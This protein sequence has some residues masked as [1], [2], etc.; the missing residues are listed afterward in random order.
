M[1]AVESVSAVTSTPA[2]TP[3][4]KVALSAADAALCARFADMLL[5]E[6]GLSANTV[7]AYGG[8]LAA[9]ARWC[10]ARGHTL[11]EATREDIVAHLAAR[12]EA[13]RSARSSARLL[14]ALR[15]FFGW[16]AREG[17]IGSDPTRL[18]VSP[19]IGRS[20]PAVPGERE[21]ERL[22]AAPDT[23]EDI[24]LRDRAMLETLYG[25]G[26]RVSELV[27]LEVD[28]INRRQGALRVSG[29]GG[30]ERLVPLG[31]PALE[32]IARYERD[33]RRELLGGRTSEALFV[34]ARGAAMTRQAFWY[35]VRQ[36]AR[37]AGIERRLSPHTLRHAFAT[38]LVNHDADLRVVQLL[39]GHR[40]LSTTQIYTHVARERLK[41]LHR[42]HHP[43]G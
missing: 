26:L 17:M 19:S 37:A 8:D 15:R 13:G 2:A 21:I 4:V 33:A 24:G 30:K 22:L 27:S 23:G 7:S 12:L 32:W 18:I 40:D 20:L 6:R 14:S 1:S 16:S 42:A 28:R 34:T 43:R 41:S 3:A 29:K 10:A 25:C 39:L 36:H 5:V 11:H 35:R 31:E 38:H 9:F